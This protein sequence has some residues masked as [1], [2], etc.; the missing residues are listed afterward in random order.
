MDADKE[1]RAMGNTRFKKSELPKIRLELLK[2]QKY[3]CPLCNKS[4]RGINISNI[5]VDHDHNSGIV[6]AA[7]HRGCNGIEGKVLI[8]LSQWGRMSTLPAMIK[9]LER[10][11]EFW[12]L[13][14]TPQT[15]WIYYGHKTATEK[16]LLI[17]K[18][19]RLKAKKLRD[20]K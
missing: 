10:L 2:K 19:R 4:M 12:K 15:K 11:I 17:N 13:H 14:I 16:R 18:R 6:R 20:K 8:L 7:M 9:Y 5:V 1:G 3:L